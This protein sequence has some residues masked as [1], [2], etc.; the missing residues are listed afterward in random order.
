MATTLSNRALLVNLQISQWTARKLDRAETQLLNQRHGL[1]V[2]AARVNKNLLPLATELERVHQIT[3]F[4]RKDFAKR[5]LP[6][7]LEGVNILKA[8][9]YVEF[10]GVVR[11]WQA[12]WHGAVDAFVA[13]YPTYREEARLLLNGMFK[14]ED[15]PHPED[16]ARRFAFN[17]RFMPMPDQQDWR[18]D[19]GD[20][21]LATLKADL[22]KDIEKSMGEAMTTA[23][24]RVYDVVSKAHER[25]SNPENVFR[26]SLVDNA[27]ELCALLPSLNV[28]DDPGMEKARQAI[29][30]SLCAVK[31]DTLRDDLSVRAKVAGDMADI[32]RKMSGAFPKAA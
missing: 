10:T 4:I 8:D 16:L 3:A 18:V 28:L 27:I 15:Y 2:E 12:E 9:A 7:G 19:I 25:L 13:A 23:W 6:W 31:P 32:L 24:L 20:E 22:A 30:R 11:Q 21:A 26:D 17:M 5:T 1:T 29:E 14:D